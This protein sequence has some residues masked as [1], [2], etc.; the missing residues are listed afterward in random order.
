MLEGVTILI[1]TFERNHL[2]C[3]NLK[4]LVSQKV[5][6]PIEV[7]VLDDRHTPDDECRK[8]VGE[9]G[10]RLG[11]QYVHSGKTK[12]SNYWRVP[13]FAFNIG[14][15]LAKHPR[16]ILCC[17]EIYH[18]DETIEALASALDAKCTPRPKHG[19]YD[20][21][22]ATR[23][24]GA[25]GYINGDDYNAIRARLPT[26]IPFLMGVRKVDYFGIG[27]YDEDFTGISEEDV[28]FVN[29]ITAFGCE[30]LEVPATRI[31]HLHHTRRR[32]S[33]ALSEDEARRTAFNRALLAKKE[34][35]GVVVSNQNREWGK[36]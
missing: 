28:D 33:G 23:A 17:A 27:G 12:G 11:A 14:A 4:T 3:W 9:Y 20:Q 35:S 32:K 30:P 8:L 18:L 34:E 15:K 24:L 5:Q 7:I 1:P 6:R 36:L 16:L 31:V 25:Q 2:L 21:G 10:E 19:K 29:R 22:P 26:E 13:G